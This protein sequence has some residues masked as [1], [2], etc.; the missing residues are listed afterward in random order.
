MPYADQTDVDSIPTRFE[1]DDS[2]QK[3]TLFIYGAHGTGT[4][5]S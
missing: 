5:F 1:V 4:H 3:R 2:A